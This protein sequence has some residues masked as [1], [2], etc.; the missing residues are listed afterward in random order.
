MLNEK[1]LQQLRTLTDF[2]ALVAYLR[3]ALDWPIDFDTIDDLADMTF[4]YTADELGLD[5]KHAVKIEHIRQI[6][7]LENDQPW[8][9]FYIEF[10][11]RRLPVMVLRRIL[12]ALV[13]ANV[14]RRTWDTQDL[15][16]ICVQGEASARGVSFAHFRKGESELSRAELRTFSWDSRETHF[17]YLTRLNLD[18]LRW[19]LEPRNHA[20]WRE[21]WRSAFTQPHRETIRT[22]E[23]LSS[24]MAAHAV[25]IRDL[26]GDLF[27]LETEQGALHRIYD[28]FREAL[29]RELSA[30]AFADMIA[31]TVTYGLF[32]A[33][34]Q[35]QGVLTYGS[36][37]EMI[38]ATNPF[39]KDLLRT[40]ID[41]G[42]IDLAELGVDDLIDMLAAADV[43]AITHDFMRQTGSGAE[44]PVIHFYEQ[45]LNEYDRKQRVERGVFYTPD[46]VVAYIVRAVDSLLKSEFG[47]ADGLASD[48]THP[49]SGEPLVQILDPATGTGTF[50]AHVI[51]LIARAQ[52]WQHSRLE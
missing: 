12:N 6:R 46:P 49:E 13:R 21:Q 16:F 41:E 8:G 34:E 11:A 29:L 18:R 7:N 33:A 30:D 17:Y 32:S 9:I 39:L 28:R 22:A 20:V 26:A 50:L 23:K 43:P 31:Q 19:P 52:S 47:L 2:P 24:A 38:P 10:E 5:A 27:R 51:D 14:N 42:G 25:V 1:T 40:L 45:F 3:D 37:V 36:V 4:D 35:G 44:D 48:A 15:L